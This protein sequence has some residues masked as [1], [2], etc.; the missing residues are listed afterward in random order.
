MPRPMHATNEKSKDFVGSI[1][2]LLSNLKPWKF[3]MTIAIILAFSSAI[4][5]GS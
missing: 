2:R 5:Y 4:P 1:K 3:L